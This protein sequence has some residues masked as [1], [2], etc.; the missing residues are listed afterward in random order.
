MEEEMT[1]E[2]IVPQYS[3]DIEFRIRE[4]ITHTLYRV[5]SKYIPSK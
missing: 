3:C 4:E 5:F 2:N 1:V